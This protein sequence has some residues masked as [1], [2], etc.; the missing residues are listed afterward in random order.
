[1]EWK[2]I[3]YG[4]QTK[5]EPAMSTSLL[6]HVFGLKGVKYISTEN[7]K[8]LTFFRAE[9][10]SVIEKCPVCGSWQT[11]RKK[12][13]KERV[14]RLVP[15]GGRP[16][17]LCLGIWRIQC[18]RCGALRWP[19]L[20]FVKGKARH[21]RRFAQFALDLVH[22]TTVLGVARVLGVGWD[23]VK[24]I[25]KEHLQSQYK[26]PPL[27]DLKYLGIDEFSIRKGHSYMSIFVDLESGRILHAVEGKGG[28]D[29]T[30]FLQVLRKKACRLEAVAMDMSTS[31]IS[32]VEEYLPHVALVFDRYHVSALMNK[33]I[34]D[35]RREQQSQLDEE[36]KKALKGT[37]FLLLKN[38]E[39]LNKEK[40][41]RLA[42]LLE[43]NAP[44]LTIHT[45]KEQLREFWEKDSMEQAIPFLHA[46][47]TDAQNS[48]VK[49]LKKIAATLMRHSHGLLNYY[50][51]RISCG[52]VEGINNKIKTLKRQAYGFRDMTYFKLRLYHLH[53]QWYSLTG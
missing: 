29:I 28:K 41:S 38:Y 12:G 53:S 44:L 51:H 47:C 24:D 16:T 5:G 26:T 48:G 2:V 3:S 49:E 23:L 27:K 35:I 15:I 37:R 50:F 21:T 32:A 34:E 45:M 14:L 1:M 7:K 42:Q 52:I 4:N 18:E 25:H 6:Y 19:Q 40:Q 36:G 22:W 8:G 13:F 10:T 20:P 17:F 39:T 46:W 9:V 30:P 31:F 33:A 43:A 11:V